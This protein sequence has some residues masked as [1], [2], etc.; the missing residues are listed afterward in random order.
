MKTVT[1]ILIIIVLFRFDGE[2]NAQAQS[3]APV[4]VYLEHFRSLEKRIL[5]VRVLTKPEKRYRPASGVEVLLYKSEI[6]E[7][8]LLGT[9]LTSDDGTGTYALNE[10]QLEFAQDKKYV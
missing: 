5:S 9:I 4:R 1:A 8:N 10:E 3:K 6:R 2:N 7:E